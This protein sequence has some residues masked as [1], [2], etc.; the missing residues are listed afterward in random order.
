MEK[1]L[2]FLSALCFFTLIGMV[3]LRFRSDR[4]NWDIPFRDDHERPPGESLRLKLDDLFTEL[5]SDFTAIIVAIVLP[6]GILPTNPH[7]YL[8]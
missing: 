1:L 4:K 3:Y 2:P 8:Y 5:T 7:P 6:L